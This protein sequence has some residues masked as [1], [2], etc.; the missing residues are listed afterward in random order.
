MNTKII[1]CWLASLALLF[2]GVSALA[3]P[4][5]N[6]RPVVKKNFKIL[7]EERQCVRC[8]LAGIDLT[9]VNLSGVNLEGANLAGA[10]LFLADLSSANLRQANLQAA[11]L[12]GA[13]LA[14]A[15]LTGANLTGAVLE[16]AYLGGAIT[17]GMIT[18]QPSGRDEKVAGETVNTPAQDQGK[19]TSHGQEVVIGERKDFEAPPPVKGTGAEKEEAESREGILVAPAGETES[20]EPLRMAEAVLPRETVVSSQTGKTQAAPPDP[21]SGSEE[22]PPLTLGSEKQVA[23]KV[24]AGPVPEPGPGAAVQETALAEEAKEEKQEESAVDQGSPLQSMIRQLQADRDGAASAPEAE[25]V[26]RTQRPTDEETQGDGEEETVEKSA[27]LSVSADATPDKKGREE[28]VALSGPQERKMET[29]AGRPPVAEQNDVREA[30]SGQPE[31]GQD[32]TA[33]VTPGQT[34]PDAETETAAD[35]SPP[36][37]VRPVPGPTAPPSMQ[38]E[39]GPTYTVETPA[40]AARRQE[41]LVERLLDEDNCPECDLAGVDLSGRRLVEVD[42][43]RANLQGANLEDANLSEANL[44]GANLAG[45]NLKNA[46]LSGADLY[47]AD[48]TG[49]DLTG[50]DLEET[51]LDS[52]VLD[53]V[54]GLPAKGG[55]AGP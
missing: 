42:L 21:V 44:K 34:E 39:Q 40:D 11:S 6:V 24:K 45:A 14:G 48:L 33:G 23:D 12:G 20:K 36:R 8:D 41:A 38:P 29:A 54:K 30:E 9:R 26:G 16:G 49:A 46:D 19:S 1:P 10:K 47:R 37:E 13:D 17:D 43:E 35:H 32:L 15:D 2:G 3:T 51:L 25:A 31:G 52:C 55:P 22:S 5:G 4:P 28:S 50:A 7:I 18:G 53:G 27:V